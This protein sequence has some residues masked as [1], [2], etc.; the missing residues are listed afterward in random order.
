[1]SFGVYTVLFAAMFR[2]LPDT[3]IDWKHVWVGSVISAT[4]FLIGK[5]GLSLYLGR[6]SY[7]QQYG[8][9]VGGFVALLVWVYYSA[10]ILLI[11]AEA[12]Q[13]YARRH[14]HRIEPDEHAVRVIKRTE[15]VPT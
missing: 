15:T 5:I 11:G 2:H 6:G 4:M 10:V 13:V 14:G 1:V 12:T 3:R 9:A 7:N 8:D